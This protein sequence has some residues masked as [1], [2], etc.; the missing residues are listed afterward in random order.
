MEPTIVV[1]AG[2]L[3]RLRGLIGRRDWPAGVALEIPRCRSVHT[4]G[5]RFPL[6]LVWLDGSRRVV[7]VDRAVPPCRVRACWRARSVLELRTPGIEGGGFGGHD[8]SSADLMG[9]RRINSALGGRGGPPTSPTQPKF[10]PQPSAIRA[11]PATTT[12]APAN[13]L[14]GTCSRVASAA[15]AVA[16]TTLVSRSAAT[17]A[18]SAVSSAARAS[19]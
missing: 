4:F 14:T 11:M 16:M 12:T 9:L 17:G 1:A 13:R 6:D 2:P 3:G 15:A 19:A 18:A 7:R 5:M 8:G 10:V